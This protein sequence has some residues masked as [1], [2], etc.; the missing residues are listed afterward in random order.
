[1]PKLHSISP[2]ISQIKMRSR[3]WPS[4]HRQA[5]TISEPGLRLTRSVRPA[6][7]GTRTHSGDTT[8]TAQETASA[9]NGSS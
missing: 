5:S 1:M 8:Y 7:K 9:T 6:L 2:P 4:S 3:G